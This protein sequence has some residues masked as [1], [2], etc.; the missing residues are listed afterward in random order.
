MSIM[1]T[2]FCELLCSRCDLDFSD[3]ILVVPSDSLGPFDRSG[4][5]SHP[6]SVRP[7]HVRDVQALF[8]SLSHPKIPDLLPFALMSPLE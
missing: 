4:P 8:I 3:R 1:D 2:Y 7:V 6:V 5:Y